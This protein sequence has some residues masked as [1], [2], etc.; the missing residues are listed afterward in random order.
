MTFSLKL[1]VLGKIFID[2]SGKCIARSEQTK[3]VKQNTTKKKSN[4]RKQNKEVSENSQ[5]FIKDIVTGERCRI[6][7]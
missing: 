3:A 6:I 7:E 4:R 1:L 5:I 2:T